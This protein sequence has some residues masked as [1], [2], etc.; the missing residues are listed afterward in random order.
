MFDTSAQIALQAR[1]IMTQ[2]VTTRAMP[3]NNLTGITDAE[4]QTLAAWV[5]GG[6]QGR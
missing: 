5:A 4:R 2:A 1:Q 6:A 3:L